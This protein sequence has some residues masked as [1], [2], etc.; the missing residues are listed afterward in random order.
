[1]YKKSAF[2]QRLRQ[3]STH[4]FDEI[5]R[6]FDGNGSNNATYKFMDLWFSDPS[7]TESVFA[8]INKPYRSLVPQFNNNRQAY[9]YKIIDETPCGYDTLP[10]GLQVGDKKQDGCVVTY[11]TCIG[12]NCFKRPDGTKFYQEKINMNYL[13]NLYLTLSVIY[14]QV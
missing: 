11:N 2:A 5:R 14:L 12:D 3:E 4:L 1:M 13:E 8:A 9:Y 7:V 10:G 6:V